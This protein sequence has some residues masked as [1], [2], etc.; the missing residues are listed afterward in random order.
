MTRSSWL[1]FSAI[2]C[3]FTL[4]AGCNCGGNPPVTP[5]TE[6]DGGTP[7]EDAGTGDPDAGGMTD[8]DGGVTDMD[9]GTDTDGGMTD[10]DGGTDPDGGMTDLDGGMMEMDAGIAPS[11]IC[12][13]VAKKKCDFAIRCK[14]DDTDDQNRTNDQVASAERAACEALETE[15]GCLIGA[16]GW[17]LGRANV[18]VTAYFACIDAQYPANT[19]ARDLNDVLANCTNLP[20]IN[21]AT[22]N[23]GLCTNDSEC[24]S[25]FC[26][27]PAADACG[28][29]QAYLP[30]GQQCQRD[31]QCNPAS[32]Y[33]D[34]TG[35]GS[36]NTCEAYT[37]LSMTCTRDDACGPGNVCASTGG[38]QRT[39]QVA[40]ALGGACTGNR[41][42]CARTAGSPLP[43]TICSSE[44]AAGTCIPVQTTA[45]GT[46]GNG[47]RIAPLFGPRGPF[48]LETEY[49]S[50]GLCTPRRTT[51]QPCTDT[52]Q[53]AMGLYCDNQGQTAT[54]QCQPY[55][56]VNQACSSSA[57]CKN[58]LT[59]A[60]AICQP[61][62]GLVGEACNAMV[63]CAEGYCD[64]TTN[65]C[66]ALEADGA[67]CT[68][69]AQCE[70]YD[71]ANGMCADAC[72]D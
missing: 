14:T 37:A 26:S 58:L 10:L 4:A 44:N 38:F 9:A 41:F 6:E 32:S 2:A 49:C 34:E 55:K 62:F 15:A 67:T 28:T 47:E 46:C 16:A 66:T 19:C 35:F 52:E 13:D 7:Q 59:C 27:V 20:F 68:G 24:S 30:N 3:A 65:M 11:N 29:C 56:D 1:W 42:Q 70:S 64:A 60:L 18:D 53:C 17:D 25:G 36:S 40:V 63:P 54:D 61:G 51:G 33:C 43:E 31:A 22:A 69:D 23:G 39:C 21:G 50:S 8:M 57:Q 5:G 12:A 71:C 72:W 45:G 48:C